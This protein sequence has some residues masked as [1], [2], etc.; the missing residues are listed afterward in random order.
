MELD[1]TYSFIYAGMTGLGMGVFT[2]HGDQ[3]RG[4]DIGRGQYWGTI[5]AGD[6]ADHVKIDI[7]MLVPF[8]GI[9]VM[10][11][12]PADINQ[13]RNWSREIPREVFTNGEFFEMFVE[14][15]MLRL[16]IQRVS[17]DWAPVLDNG[18]ALNLPAVPAQRPA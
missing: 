4:M 16:M 6:T 1:G 14:P 7:T 17:D 9:L 12:A 2:V 8:G 13:F 15:G 3:L 11:T 18:W 5:V 10:G